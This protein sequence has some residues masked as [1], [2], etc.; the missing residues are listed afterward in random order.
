MTGSTSVGRVPSLV[1]AL[2]AF[3][4]HSFTLPSSPGEPHGP[5]S[6]RPPPASAHLRQTMRTALEGTEFGRGASSAEQ[7][8]A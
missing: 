6:V 1:S 4:L 7:N 2:T 3:K 5:A 8:R